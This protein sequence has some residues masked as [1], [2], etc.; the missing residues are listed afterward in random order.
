M[1]VDGKGSMNIQ[2]M[3]NAINET[4]ETIRSYDTKSEILGI[5]VTLVVGIL[6]FN[7]ITDFK[8]DS[9]VMLFIIITTT[10]ALISI[11][12]ILL[13]LFPARNPIEEIDLGGYTPKG[14]RI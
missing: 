12:F 7:M 4:Q 2:C 14:G 10:M 11:M 3:T 8:K 1:A 9:L 13:V 6:N 5:L